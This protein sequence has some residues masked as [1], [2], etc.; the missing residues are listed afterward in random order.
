[1]I[2]MQIIS[3]LF[4]CSHNLSD[5]FVLKIIFII[6]VSYIIHVCKLSL[7]LLLRLHPTQ[8]FPL[9][10]FTPLSHTS[11]LLPF[12]NPPFHSPFSLPLFTPFFHSPFSLPLFH[13]TFS[14]PLFIP[15]FH[16]PL[17]HFFPSTFLLHLSTPLYPLT[18]SLS[19]GRSFTQ[20]I[21]SGN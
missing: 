14:L 1:M 10:V 8:P 7:Y 6:F 19:R 16:S 21:C 20:L 11:F 12:P 3:V 4:G 13:S 9:P 18:G 2:S 5:I 15:P 17:S